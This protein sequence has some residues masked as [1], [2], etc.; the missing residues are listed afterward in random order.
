M[1]PADVAGLQDGLGATAPIVRASLAERGIRFRIDN[2]PQRAAQ[3]R[4]PV[5][6]I[7][8]VSMTAAGVVYPVT[9]AALHH[10]SPIMIATL[11]ALVGGAVLTGMLPLM[12]SRLPRTRRLWIWAFAIGLGNTTLTQVGIS[13]G[14]DRAGAAVAAVLLNSSPFFVAVIARFALAESITRL[15]A[16]GLVIGFGGVLVVVFSDPGTIAHGS[17]LAIGF[18]LSLLG[19]LGWAGGGLGMRV[20]TQREPDLDIPGITAAQFLAGG[21]PLIPLVVLAGGSTQWSRPSLDAQLVYLI[22]GGQVLV[23][24]G[25]NAA[26]SR[27]PSTRVYAWTFLVPAVAVVIEAVRGRLPGAVATIGVALVILGVAIVNLPRA[28]VAAEAGPGSPVRQTARAGGR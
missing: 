7:L 15:R 16:A 1:R 6:T 3:Q 11:R 19:A 22:L 13:V 10:T 17:R 8:G 26:L 2:Q 4:L 5:S 25:F 14:T 24:L 20:L 27:W 21:I 23:Y 28:E 18:A 12:G 9:D